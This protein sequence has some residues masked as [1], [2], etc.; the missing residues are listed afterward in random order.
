MRNTQKQNKIFDLFLVCDAIQELHLVNLMKETLWSKMLITVASQNELWLASCRRT[1][2]ALTQPFR[3]FTP[4]WPP[5]TPGF[6]R[7]LDNSQPQTEFNS[8]TLL[9]TM[10]WPKKSH[11]SCWFYQ[12]SPNDNTHIPIWCH[13]TIKFYFQFKCSFGR[14][15]CYLTAWWSHSF[16]KGIS[17]R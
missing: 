1:K 16:F 5:T 17:Y 3:R 12:K 7:T 4:V 2:D 6:F 14:N 11:Y 9:L 13:I 10:R 8:N 15:A